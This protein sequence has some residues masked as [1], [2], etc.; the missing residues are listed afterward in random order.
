M[1]A[2]GKAEEELPDAPE[3]D[4]A[5]AVGEVMA[6][7]DEILSTQLSDL[8]L[9]QARACYTDADPFGTCVALSGA[10][11]SRTRNY[12]GCSVYQGEFSGS[13][14]L[15]FSSTD[16]TVDSTGKSVSWIPQLTIR[17][18]NQDRSLT[19]SVD[20]GESGVL[21]T[22][23][24]SDGLYNVRIDGVRRQATRDGAVV[25]NHRFDSASSLVVTGLS[26]ST[27][28]LGSGVLEVADSLSGDQYELRPESLTWGASC[29]CASSGNWTGTRV[30]S[31][32]A[33]SYITVELMGCGEAL[34]TEI[35][36]VSFTESEVQIDRCIT[37]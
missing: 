36:G 33:L 22:R 2:C 10:A 12:G 18:R 11:S 17:G 34:V 28:T 9:L 37:I 1:L 31:G 20:S 19:V 5:N 24:T 16:C 4:I 26:R 6:S 35:Q 15:I 3:H 23:G 32:G 7:I 30:A 21:L 13:V 27:R 8:S 25:L 14:N 29:T